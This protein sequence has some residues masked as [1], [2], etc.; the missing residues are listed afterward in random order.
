MSERLR[1]LSKEG[2]QASGRVMVS[3]QDPVQVFLSLLREL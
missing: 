1:V 3:Y 2:E